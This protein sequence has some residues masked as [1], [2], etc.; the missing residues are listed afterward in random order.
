VRQQETSLREYARAI[1]DP[2]DAIG[3]IQQFTALGMFEPPESLTRGVAPRGDVRDFFQ[4][5][6]TPDSVTEVKS[7]GG[8]T[9]IFLTGTKIIDYARLLKLFPEYEGQLGNYQEQSRLQDQI[10]D[11]LHAQIE[12]KSAQVTNLEER[13]TT[14]R[15]RSEIYKT[16]AEINKEGFWDKFMKH[17]ALPVGL[18]VG[19]LVGAAVN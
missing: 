4:V 11:K 15:E 16:M 18:V 13:N 3:T 10:I 9:G 17:A 19:L 14:E 12:V 2:D 5:S 7:P 8:K 6:F 1:R